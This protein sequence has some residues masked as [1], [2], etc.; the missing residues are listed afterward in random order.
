MHIPSNDLEIR[1]PV[2]VWPGNVHLV[3]PTGGVSPEG[4][5]LRDGAGH[6][7]S[8]VLSKI[9]AGGVDV[10]KPK[11]LLMEQ[12]ALPHASILRSHRL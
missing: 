1:R 5:I 10:Q 6:S 8:D 7:G 9:A 3:R 12:K 11:S 2:K 4:E